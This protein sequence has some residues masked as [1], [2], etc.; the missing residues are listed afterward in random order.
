[1]A[2]GLGSGRCTGSRRGLGLGSFLARPSSAPGPGHSGPV[3]LAGSVRKRPA[4][5]ARPARP[6]R[7]PR[8]GALPLRGSG[9][10]AQPEPLGAS[11]PGTTKKSSE[12]QSKAPEE[13]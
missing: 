1:M 10:A 12:S 13:P 5:S 7:R 2:A 9:A 4:P 3:E 8:A 11:K 6:P